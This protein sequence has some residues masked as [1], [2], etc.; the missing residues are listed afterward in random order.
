MIGAGH[1]EAW[2]EWRDALG[3]E[4]MHHGWILAGQRGLGKRSF[5]EAA[6]RELLGAQRHKGA[7]PDI[8]VLTNLPK[9]TAAEKARDAGKPYETKRNITVDQ[10]REMQKRLTTRPT[11]GDKR[12]II[13]D[14]ADDME[15]GAA[16][17]LL[18][19]LE[20]PPA[21]TF[22]L[23]LSHR[24]ARLLAT[25][26]SRCRM[27]RFPALAD[28]DVS[29]LLADS[30]PEADA[31]ARD[32][33]VKA[34]RG[35]PGIALEFLDLELGG[36]AAAMES[37]LASGD[38][39]QSGRGALSQALGPRP[40]REKMQA[41]LELARAILAGHAS[42]AHASRIPALVDAHSELVRLSGQA[43]TYNFEPGL[44][45]MEIGGLLARAAPTSAPAD[46]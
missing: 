7:H 8:I 6:A 12:A 17:A 19:S 45:A 3:G 2:K 31:Q 4:R 15:K 37:I 40:S 33:A 16:N 21:G 28:A 26:R 39:D 30:A 41:T 32:A 11:L 42:A 20:E 29:R 13:I 14:P 25:I 27:L 43:P 46:G 10:I 23:L 35:S 22:F 36:A 1:S 18:K 9:D 34:A 38:R 44:L 24:P 5:A